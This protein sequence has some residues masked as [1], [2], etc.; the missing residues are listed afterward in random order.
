MVLLAIN[1][2]Y[3]EFY[4][5]EIEY[6]KS[7]FESVKRFIVMTTEY[8]RKKHNISDKIDLVSRK[9][10]HYLSHSD[11]IYPKKFSKHKFYKE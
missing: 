7:N 2:S 8:L 1:E 3:Y 4:S 11:F 9:Q 6:F 5:H 10:Y